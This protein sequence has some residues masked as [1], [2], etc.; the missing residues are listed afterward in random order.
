MIVVNLYLV[1]LEFYLVHEKVEKKINPNP[2]KNI[3]L[4]NLKS[5]T[6][7]F[8][9]LTNMKSL[10]IYNISHRFNLTLNKWMMLIL[11][12]GELNC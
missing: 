10:N 3:F 9:D 7:V 8:E 11:L 6:A 5:L 4:N 1:Y 12:T 2:L